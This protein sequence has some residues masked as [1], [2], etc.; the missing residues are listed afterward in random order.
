MMMMM[1]K[2]TKMSL[3]PLLLMLEFL[4]QGTSGA[5]V[6]TQSPAVK[7][8][9]LGANVYLSCTASQGVDDDLSWYLQKPGQSPKLRFYK[10]SSRESETPSHF[11]S[12]GSE[13]DF[14]LTISG[15][16]TDDVG[17]YY[18]MG[19]CTDGNTQ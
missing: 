6:V 8:V 12:S 2:T 18:C 15:V 10:I 16:Q 13:P 4:S 17:D 3:I 9:T 1:M 19:A 11:S 7:S 14:T 5:G